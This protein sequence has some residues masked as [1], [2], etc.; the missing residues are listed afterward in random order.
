MKTVN[1]NVNIVEKASRVELLIRLVYW[2]P[3]AIMV[4]ILGMIA[5]LFF[6]LQVIVI[7]VS[8][9]RHKGLSKWI[10]VAVDYEYKMNIYLATVTDERPP[11][12]PEEM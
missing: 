2:I 3:L 8:G 6:L 5:V 11:I 4:S 9:K 1:T 10:R 7:L 12:L